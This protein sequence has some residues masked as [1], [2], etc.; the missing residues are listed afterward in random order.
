MIK[1]G[2]TRSQESHLLPLE[3]HVHIIVINIYIAKIHIHLLGP[4]CRWK[5]G[6]NKWESEETRAYIVQNKAFY[7]LLHWRF[8]VYLLGI[9]TEILDFKNHLSQNILLTGVWRNYFNIVS[10]N[11]HALLHW[12]WKLLPLLHLKWQTQWAVQNTGEKATFYCKQGVCILTA[13]RESS[14]N[15]SDPAKSHFVGKRHNQT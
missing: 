15:G 13:T 12:C 1:R 14:I 8:I 10:Y 11:Q 6:V 4:A 9:Y 7:H 5:G 3:K 2:F